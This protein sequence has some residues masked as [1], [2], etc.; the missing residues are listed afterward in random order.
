[1]QV[2]L[3]GL[4]GDADEASVQEELARFFHIK[5]VKMIRHGAA[6]NPW[7]LLEVTGSYEH[8][9]RVCNRLRGVF[10]N[11]KALHLYIPLHQEDVYHDF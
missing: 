6:D 1:M 10:R 5:R 9:W 8:N 3:S 7:A 2:I 4:H 11:G